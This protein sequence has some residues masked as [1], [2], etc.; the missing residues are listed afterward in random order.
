MYL[1]QKTF[2]LLGDFKEDVMAQDI[3]TGFELVYSKRMD[4]K[5]SVNQ[6]WYV[7]FDSIIV[8]NFCPAYVMLTG[9]SASLFIRNIEKVVKL[10]YDDYLEYIIISNDSICGESVVRSSVKIRTM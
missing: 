10:T 7:H 5:K 4:V 2:E 9:K 6:L 3:K 1:E 8:Q